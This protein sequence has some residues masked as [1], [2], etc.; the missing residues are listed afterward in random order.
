M[1][2]LSGL[3]GSPRVQT[4]PRFVSYRDS[5]SGSAFRTRPAP[6]TQEEAP[7]LLVVQGAR[8]KTSASRLG[9]VLEVSGRPYCGGI[10]G[11]VRRQG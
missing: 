10:H 7:G 4:G 9:G 3:P 2:V 5:S 11:A 1:G 6:S 8:I